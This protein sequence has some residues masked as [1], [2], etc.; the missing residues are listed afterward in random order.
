VDDPDCWLVASIESYD[1]E[2][3]LA[4]KG[5]I[6]SERVIAPLITS[7]TDAL[8]VTLNETGRRSWMSAFRP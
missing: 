3:G 7:A 5:P 8:A 4:R 2:T 6:F 1:V